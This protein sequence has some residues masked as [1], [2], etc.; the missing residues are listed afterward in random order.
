MNSTINIL[1][2]DDEKEAC[3]NLRNILADYID[4]NTNVVGVAH[5]T[6]EA[7]LQI[8]ALAP[9]VVFLDI[10][11]PNENAF[12]FL[13]RQDQINFEIIF[14]TAYDEYALRAFR[15]NAVDYILK[16]I[17]IAE[18]KKAIEKLQVRLHYK[19]LNANAAL[20]YNNLS[21]Q[22]NQKE[23]PHQIVLRN[24]N[25]YEVVAF[26]DILYAEA[27]GSYCKVVFYKKNTLHNVLMASNIANYEEIFPK[28]TFFR[29]HRSYLVNC[30]HINRL[31]KE[32]ELLIHLNNEEKI[33]VSRRRYPDFKTFLK[34]NNFFDQHA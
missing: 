7:A 28:T 11:M 21:K 24:N 15:L 5:D 12:Q 3:N 9:D 26:K 20:F 32:E 6:K 4:I 1:I 33:P 16:P 13:E 23:A 31:S 2:V 8:Q 29:V 19:R 18:L 27:S 22:I 30:S 25:T 14:I 10:E 34:H 17:N